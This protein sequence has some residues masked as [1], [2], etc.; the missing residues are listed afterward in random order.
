MKDIRLINILKTFSI[1][2]MKLFGKFVASPY[3]NSGK[4]CMPL[5]KLLQKS[6][7]DFKAG[8]YTYE[9][10]H[11]KLYPGR[12]FNKQV[13]WNLTSAMEKMTKEFLKQEA[14]KKNGFAQMELALS[15]FGTRKLY[16][17]YSGTLSEMDKLLDKSGIEYEYF[18]KKCRLEICKQEY[19]FS[20]DKVQFKGDSTLKT[21]EWAA[22]FFLRITV[23]GLRDL[24]IL[25]EYHN[26]K[27]EVNIPM[28]F[29]KKLE[30]ESIVDYANR[31]NFEYAYLIEIYYHSLMMLLEPE[32]TWHLDKYRELFEAHFKKFTQNEQSSMMHDIINYCLYNLELGKDKFRRI[33][34]EL[35]EFRL[36]EG[37]A[38]Y[39]E[40]Q[41][42]KAIYLQILNAAIDVNETR[43]AEDFIK[44]YTI[45]L[46]PAYRDSMK[47]MA[48][49]FLYFHTKEYM[50]VFENLTKV[51]FVDIRDKLQTRVLSAKS[52]YELG[53]TETLLNIID[54]SKHFINN[55]PSVSEIVRIHAHN[56]FK[57]LQK[58]VFVKESK[59]T[60]EIR[61][62]KNEIE[63]NKEISSKKWLLEKLSEL[64]NRK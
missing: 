57:Y 49:A 63:N 43:W 55:N 7:P 54:S 40:N 38:F 59:D 62:L 16:N 29:V 4:S 64:E 17:N 20:I 24:K 13:T 46:L 22:I 48:Y 51:E 56:F 53:E 1:E 50:K 47:C 37:L 45:W 39:P 19:Y 25:E 23:G 61:I 3:H 31:N 44:K 30:L 27:I 36:K 6:F 34:F 10:I 42:S 8:N 9:A 35:N 18:G 60:V 52:Y 11:K 32:Q 21:S 15:E 5:Y 33:V 14:L 28:E 58:L 41:L 26:Y 12:K 2:E